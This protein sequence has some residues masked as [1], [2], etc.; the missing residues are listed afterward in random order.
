MTESATP[1][2]ITVSAGNRNEAPRNQGKTEAPDQGRLYTR[3]LQAPQRY[4]YHPNLDRRRSQKLR[5]EERS[6]SL[7]Q[8]EQCFRGLFGAI[9]Y[10]L[11][12]ASS[13]SKSDRR[14]GE[15]TSV[16]LGCSLFSRVYLL[17]VLIRRSKLSLLPL[18]R[19]VS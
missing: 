13:K 15:T 1:R 2:L 18:T 3:L 11:G 6:M 4:G 7:P 12:M 8:W 9:A 5:R 16:A 19:L 17:D 10:S 14:R